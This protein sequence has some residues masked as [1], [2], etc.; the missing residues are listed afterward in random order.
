MRM[1]LP[2]VISCYM[3]WY[4]LSAYVYCFG[5]HHVADSRTKDCDKAHG[6]GMQDLEHAI[7]EASLRLAPAFEVLADPDET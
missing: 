4:T 1:R 2:T 5:P 7:D 6:P 3:T